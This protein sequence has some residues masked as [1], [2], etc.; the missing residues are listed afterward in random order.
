MLSKIRDRQARFLAAHVE[1]SLRSSSHPSFLDPS[2]PGP[3][4]RVYATSTTPAHAPV[5]AAAMR[6]RPA[7]SP[8][9]TNNHGMNGSIAQ[10]V[11]AKRPPMVM[12]PTPLPED[13]HAPMD[14]FY[15]P[16]TSAQETLNI[17]EACMFRGHD[18]P[19]ARKLLDSM[20]S[21]AA[22]NRSVPVEVSLY[23]QFIVTYFD[24]ASATED[25]TTRENLVK[26]AWSVYRCIQEDGVDPDYTTYAAVLLI[27]SK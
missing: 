15:F 3:S 6:Q 8:T 9:S 23:N 17:I 25:N 13:E 7:H 2:L 22:E 27:L 21:D 18:M 11:F 10:G 20:R 16:R 14:Q 26:E 24:L 12:L 4:R 19:R 1:N 5:A